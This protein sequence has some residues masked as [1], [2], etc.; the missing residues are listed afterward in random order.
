LEH[1]ISQVSYASN[2]SAV[3]ATMVRPAAA[4][5]A[6]PAVIVIHEAWG[7]DGHI[8]DIAGRIA[9]A[10]YLA[11]VPDLYA[12]GGARPPELAPDR[13]DALKRFADTLPPGGLGNAK[14]RGEALE[15]MPETER[16]RVAGSIVALF[17]GLAAPDR[18]V[19]DLRGAVAHLRDH[20]DC[21]GQIGAIGF[22]MGGGLVGLLACDEGALR[23]GVIYYGT[24]PPDERVGGIACP[25]LGIYGGDDGRIT[26]AV[27]AFADA[28]AAA[29]KR[30]DHHVYPGAPH[31]F[32][33]D[34]RPAYRVAP[35][36][37][38][39]A[40]TLAFLVEQLG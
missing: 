24:P 17:A 34:T 11:L 5:G 33:N 22:C 39:W 10:G 31:A 15:G 35:A 32:F 6:L 25:L 18:F 27:P 30:F 1:S 9:A 16:T 40:R 37:D 38:A 36:R 21:N 26:S 7:A 4:S 3:P 23:A 12:H 14:V 19:A 29:G 2:G 8:R 28:M 20:P 13:I